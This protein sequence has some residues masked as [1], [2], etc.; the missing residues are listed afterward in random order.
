MKKILI[1]PALFDHVDFIKEARD[2][3]YQVI[4]CDNNKK[5]LGHKYA[6]FSANISL[7][8]IGGL[9]RFAKEMK[10][11]AVAAYSTDIGAIPAAFIASDLGLIGNPVNAVTVMSN[12]GVFR[13]FLRKNIFKTPKYQVVS[14]IDEL[15][16]EYLQFPVIIKPTDRAGSKGINIVN[17]IQNL[18][19]KI[20]VSLSF[21]FEKK[22]IVEEYIETEYKQ[23]HGDAIVQ[24]GE[25]LFLGLGDQYFGED[26]LRFSPIATIFPTSI[27]EDIFKKI[28]NEIRRFIQLV[29]YKNGGIN[30]EIRI[31]RNQEI[32]F[33]ELAPRLGGNYIPKVIS[34]VYN[35]NVIKCAFDIAI[36]KNVFLPKCIIQ[37]N[38]F[39]LILRSNKEG[40]FRSVFIQNDESFKILENY[41][42]KS[43]GDIVTCNDSVSSIITVYIIKSK[44]K[45]MIFEIINDT[46]KFF[47]IHIT[48]LK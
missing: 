47:E 39:Q 12:K 7:L 6:H 29:K 3:N 32:Y 9:R 31:G 21:S 23:I 24:N 45:E 4:T 19:T 40:V 37:N 34:L 11:D 26:G 16:L 10:I 17:N 27:P 48:P 30:I 2:N 36:G 42:I 35:I 22:V 15:N 46:S 13:G 18:K 14:C 20:G 44:N 8:D 33:V 43:S 41:P 38:I 1:V 25:L 28:Q 5:N